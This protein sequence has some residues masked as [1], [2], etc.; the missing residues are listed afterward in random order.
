MFWIVNIRHFWI[1]V[2]YVTSKPSRQDCLVVGKYL[3]TIKKNLRI[4]SHYCSRRLDQPNLQRV[5][6]AYK[7][8]GRYLLY[9]KIKHTIVITSNVKICK[10]LIAQRFWHQKLHLIHIWKNKKFPHR[11]EIYLIWKLVNNYH[12]N[13]NKYQ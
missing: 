6:L 3:S 4:N 8:F 12:I 9:A 7:V 11:L 10:I 5:N 1:L 13:I 2:S